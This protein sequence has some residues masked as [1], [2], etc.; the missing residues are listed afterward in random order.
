MSW[1]FNNQLRNRRMAIDD[2]D[3]DATP[4]GMVPIDRTVT[5]V[6]IVGAVSGLATLAALG[7][8]LRISRFT[9]RKQRAKH[10][11]HSL[12]FFCIW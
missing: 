7:F 6:R 8:F 10:L 2:H 4:A 5:W 12:S 1:N 3:D 11:F 9:T